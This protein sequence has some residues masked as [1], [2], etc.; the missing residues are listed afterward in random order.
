MRS[1]EQFPKALLVGPRGGIE[2]DRAA[3]GMRS[4]GRNTMRAANESAGARI[5][6]V[7]DDEWA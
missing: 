2:F 6:W 3:R 5:H 7:Y 4:I 1:R